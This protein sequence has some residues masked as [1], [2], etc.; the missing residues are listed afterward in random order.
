MCRAQH[1]V[2]QS[3]RPAPSLWS[4]CRDG[5]T[6]L[7]TLS[8]PL[9]VHDW[10]SVCIPIQWRVPTQQ[11][12]LML[13]S[14]L[15]LSLVLSVPHFWWAQAPCQRSQE[16]C[17]LSPG[18]ADSHGLVYKSQIG[19]L[20]SPKVLEDKGLL[21]VAQGALAVATLAHLTILAP[22]LPPPLFL[23]PPN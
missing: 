21:H 22:P 7:M 12:P 15:Q 13:S 10:A 1:F 6:C 8:V 14:Q 9:T 11:I 3:G 17:L 2:V 23:H 4:I 20:P 19:P 5:L 16:V 18:C